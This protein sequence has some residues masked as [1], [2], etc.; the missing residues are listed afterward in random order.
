MPPM[1]SQKGTGKKGRDIRQSRSRNTTPSLAGTMSEADLGDTAYLELP[2]ASFKTS[3]ELVE[4]YGITIPSSKELELL[5]ERL[6]RLTEIIETR[7]LLC[8]RGVRTVAQARKERYEEIESER[9]EEE[10]KERIKRE[11]A[12][13]E[14]RSKNKANKI[15]KKK[16]IKEE[17]PPAVG[18]HGIAPQD[19]SDLRMFCSVSFSPAPVHTR[20]HL[21]LKITLTPPQSRPILSH[22]RNYNPQTSAPKLR[23]RLC[24][25]LL[26]AC[27]TCNTSHRYGYRQ[28]R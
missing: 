6:K 26:I 4:N 28:E 3:D 11:V 10:M 1:S 19:G 14:E 21:K 13:E 8:D 12:D 25:L 18:A 15:K 24:K 9:R 16:D 23:H 2:I 22:P 5:L 27:C 20:H 17:R 7:S